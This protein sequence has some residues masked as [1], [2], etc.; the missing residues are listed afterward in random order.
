MSSTN[1]DNNDMLTNNNTDRKIPSGFSLIPG[2][3]KELVL[4]PTFLVPAIRVALKTDITRAAMVTDD[5][6]PGVSYLEAS[7]GLNI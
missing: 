6:T 3:D 4:V 7:L 1:N 2:P 5:A